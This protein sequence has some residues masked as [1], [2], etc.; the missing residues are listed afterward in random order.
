MV[1]YE[2]ADL[3]GSRFDDVDLRDA[4]LRGVCL[5]DVVM[6]GC[7]LDGVEIEAEIRGGRCGGHPRRRSPAQDLQAAADGY[8]VECV[9]RPASS[10][11]ATG[12]P[13]SMCA[14]SPESAAAPTGS[15]SRRTKSPRLPMPIVG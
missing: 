3:R 14:A 7:V 9:R 4:E 5:K 15:A 8:N 11:A 2:H 12:I 10:V 1:E 6:K 13:R